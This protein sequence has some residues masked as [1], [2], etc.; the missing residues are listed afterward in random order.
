MDNRV[1]AYSADEK[2]RPN[3]KKSFRG[4]SSAGYACK[5]DMS[6]DGRCANYS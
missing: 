5:P 1:V 2:F 4:H 6:T 3:S